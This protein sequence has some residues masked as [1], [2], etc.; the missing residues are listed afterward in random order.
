M[1]NTKFT[2]EQLIKLNNLQDLQINNGIWLIPSLR[3]AYP[4]L[5]NFR[6]EK[7]YYDCSFL[8]NK[9]NK[10]LE[11]QLQKAI[12]SFM[13]SEC[14]DVE[15]VYNPI[16]NQDEKYD[17][18]ENGGVMFTAS[19]SYKI[20]CFSSK[21]EI[22]SCEE[23]YGGMWCFAS[24]KPYI[25]GTDRKGVGFSLRSIMK[26]ADDNKFGGNSIVNDFKE[27]DIKK[28]SSLTEDASVIF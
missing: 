28:F 24:V 22:I 1:K 14:K 25:Y 23:V 16:R 15:N 12:L 3:I 9:D 19:S 4:N 18:F 2:N 11:D 27:V 8:V 13:A 17:G 20:K 5:V 6:K 26:I 21:K 7:N 10:K